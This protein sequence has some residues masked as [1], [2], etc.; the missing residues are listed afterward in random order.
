MYQH[1]AESDAGTFPSGAYVLK[2]RLT[3]AST[4]EGVSGLSPP[5]GAAYVRSGLM[6][7]ASGVEGLSDFIPVPGLG[8]FMKVMIAVLEA[9]EVRLT[10]LVNCAV[11]YGAGSNCN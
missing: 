8:E 2:R 7:A 3:L 11:S 10:F 5:S 1:A 6:M 9:C 4:A